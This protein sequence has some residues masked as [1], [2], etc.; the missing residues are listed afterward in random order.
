[1]TTE[2]PSVSAASY[3]A[4]EGDQSIR[5]YRDQVLS[6]VNAGEHLPGG[7]SLAGRVQR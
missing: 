4:S 7:C 1:M 2:S 6:L 3:T 5:A